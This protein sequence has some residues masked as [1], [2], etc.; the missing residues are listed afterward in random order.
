MIKQIM[1]AAVCAAAFLSFSAV[2]SAETALPLSAVPDSI[3]YAQNQPP[4]FPLENIAREPLFKFCGI[5]GDTYDSR[6]GIE[7]FVAGD[8]SSALSYLQRAAKGGNA[9]CMALLGY[10][11]TAGLGTAKNSQVAQNMFNRAVKAGNMLAHC[12]RGMV[13]DD[14]ANAIIE[15]NLAATNGYPFGVYLLA[16]AKW[17]GYGC[18]RN[19]DDSV[20]LLEYLALQGWPVY[21]EIGKIYTEGKVV[22]PDYEKAFEY[23]TKD[24]VQY[25]NYELFTLAQLYYYGRGTGD[26]VKHQKNNGKY[27]V[28]FYKKGET[29]RASI[30]DALILLDR[31]VAGGYENAIAL[32]M[33]VKSEYEERE[34]EY[35]KTT[36]PQF[37]PAV[38]SYLSR[39]PSPQPPAIASAGRGEIII[40]ARISATGLVSDAR[41]EAR[42]LQRLDEAALSLV[43]GMPRWQPGTRGG[44]PAAMSV[45][46]GIQYFPQRVRVIKYAPVR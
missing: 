17:N 31:L 33:A 28:W 13:Q 5:Q 43:R 15:Y 7:L 39:T 6:R 38:K 16:R 27:S 10:M 30:T 12:F 8:Y 4:R 36:C 35:N 19:Y 44:Q 40:R 45:D 9:D 46:I 22:A 42:V 37:T 11:Y 41:I 18:E 24:G 21:G 23:L 14:A 34:A 29:G 1:R 2:S 20:T 26:E 25:T 32:Q 3:S